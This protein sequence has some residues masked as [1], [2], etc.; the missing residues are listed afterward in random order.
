MMTRFRPEGTPELSPGF[1][2][3]VLF[4]KPP[5]WQLFGDLVDLKS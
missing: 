1:Q 5:D 3:W 2:P 4:Q